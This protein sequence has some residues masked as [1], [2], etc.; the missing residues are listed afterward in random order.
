[1]P[2]QNVCRLSMILQK[3]SNKRDEKLKT[4]DISLLRSSKE[5]LAFYVTSYVTRL[6]AASKL[7]KIGFDTNRW[8]VNFQKSVRKSVNSF[9]GNN[10]HSNGFIA[11]ARSF[12]GLTKSKLRLPALSHASACATPMSFPARASV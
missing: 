5:L 11:F 2:E 9:G 6:L 7:E 3:G 1:M 8:S 12:K 10:E 4:S